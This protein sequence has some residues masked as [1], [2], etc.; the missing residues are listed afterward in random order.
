MRLAADGDA[1]M[2]EEQMEKMFLTLARQRRGWH[3]PDEA[4]SGD[5]DDGIAIRT[6][7]PFADAVARVAEA[8]RASAC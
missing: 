6:S 4:G 5:M 7:A 2:T 1:P 8:L 3:S